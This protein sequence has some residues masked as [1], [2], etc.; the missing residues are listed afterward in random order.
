[1]SQDLA[2]QATGADEGVVAIMTLT[3]EPKVQ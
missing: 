2:T 1:M 3:V